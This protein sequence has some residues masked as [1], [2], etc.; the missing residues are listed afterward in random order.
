MFM[1]LLAALQ[2]LCYRYTGQEDVVVSTGTSNRNHPD[3]EDLIGCF[4]NILLM[5][6][7]LSGNPSFLE[8]LGRVRKVAV[9]AY[10]HQDFTFELLVEALGP[11]RDLSYNPLS[12][13]MLV[14]HNAPAE[15]MRLKDL[16]IEPI[17]GQRNTAQ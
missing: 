2:T 6:S 12:Q 1:T 16:V 9:D 17:E 4:I 13:V 10:D 14:L 15:A 5:R 11:E 7:D 3:T 8:L